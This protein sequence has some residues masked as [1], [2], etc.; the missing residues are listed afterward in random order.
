MTDMQKLT[1]LSRWHNSQW[2]SLHDALVSIEDGNLYVPAEVAI[3]LEEYLEAADY[4]PEFCI[5]A[6]GRLLDAVNAAILQKRELDFLTQLFDDLTYFPDKIR[7]LIE[8]G[9][10][11][12]E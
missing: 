2:L 12:N 8:G 1:A 5:A 4:E 3:R 6:F 10:K 11:P 7:A 9:V